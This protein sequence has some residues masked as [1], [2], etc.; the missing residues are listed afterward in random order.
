[1]SDEIMSGQLIHRCGEIL[2]CRRR[3]TLTCGKSFRAFPF[4]LLALLLMSTQTFYVASY[5]PCTVHSATWRT[6]SMS[7]ASQKLTVEV[8]D[9]VKVML[10]G[11]YLK[12]PSL[13][14]VTRPGNGPG[15]PGTFP[16]RRARSPA[17]P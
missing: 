11:P 5:S 15:I 1:M 3:Q 10:A 14:G 2:I 7:S 13:F 4:H 17:A 6:K 8:S 12:A 9:Y 16:G